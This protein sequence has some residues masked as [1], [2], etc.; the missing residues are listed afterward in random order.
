M[1]RQG[2]EG[3]GLETLQLGIF[4]AVSVLVM[5]V[6]LSLA[7]LVCRGRYGWLRLSLWLMAALVV[8]WL[9]VLGPFFII[10]MIASGGNVPLLALFAVVAVA[11]GI[12]FGVL[13]PFLVL[14]FANG[15]YRERLKGLL[16]LGGAAPP[17]VIT[18]ANAG[19]WL[20]PPRKL[21]AVEAG[22]RNKC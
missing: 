19:S 8:V 9:L 5:S 11:T 13:L 15:F 6:A 17:P 2:W 3:V 4:L 20:R 7:G 1:V 10:A 22:N 18:P 14:S 21:K 16:H 12:T